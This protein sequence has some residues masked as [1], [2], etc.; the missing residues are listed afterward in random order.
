MAVSGAGQVGSVCPDLGGYLRGGG[1]GGHALRVGDVGND[2]AHREG[3]GRISP[4]G[5]LQGDGKQPWKVQDG[6]WVYTPLEEAMAET[7]L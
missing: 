7:G 3:F 4:Q 2:T 5:G 1:S 6:G